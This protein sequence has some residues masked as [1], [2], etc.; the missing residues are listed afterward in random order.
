MN[1][2]MKLERERHLG[3]APW[4]RSPARVGH[5]NGFK[6]KTLKTRVGELARAACRRPA[7]GIFIRVRWN[8]AREASVP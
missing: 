5:A 7:R 8:A 2:A 3:A 1:A 4:Q 6:D